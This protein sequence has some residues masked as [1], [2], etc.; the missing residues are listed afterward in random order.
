MLQAEIFREDQLGETVE[1]ASYA[2]PTRGQYP[3]EAYANHTTGIAKATVASN[4][5]VDVRIR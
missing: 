2:Y 1:N 5:T 4:V 3:I